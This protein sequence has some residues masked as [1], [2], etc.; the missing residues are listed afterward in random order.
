LLLGAQRDCDFFYGV[1]PV[2]A[3]FYSAN[4]CEPAELIATFNPHNSPG[5]TQLTLPRDQIECR[6][7]HLDLYLRADRRAARREDKHAV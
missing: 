5:A 3:V 1:V 6:N 2:C 7:V 4:D